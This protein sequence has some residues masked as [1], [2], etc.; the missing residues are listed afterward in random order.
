MADEFSGLA[1][2]DTVD[3][4]HLRCPTCI[5]GV[6]GLPN[7]PAKMGLVTFSRILDKLR[8][9]DTAASSSATGRSPS[10]TGRSRTTWP[11]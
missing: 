8:T 4:C 7:T 9:E 10:S 6:R 2:V 5:R 1:L 3:A 11:A